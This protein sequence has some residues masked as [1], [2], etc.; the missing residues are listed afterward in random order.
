MKLLGLTLVFLLAVANCKG[1]IICEETNPP[2]KC[3]QTARLNSGNFADDFIFGVASS[4]YQI[5]GGRGRGLNVWDGFTHRFPEKGGADLG[6]GD[7]TCDAYRTWQ[8]DVDVMAELGVK[9]YRFSFAWSRI[10]PRGK[11]SR[12]VNEDG[13][14]YYS[15]LIDALLEKGITP[16]VTIY[17]WDLPQCLQ[18]EYEGFLS[19]EIIEDFKEYADLCFERFGDRVKNWITINQLFTVPT[20]GY[21]LGTDAPGRCSKWVS[22][23]CPGGDSATE[24]YLV[25]H[26]QLLAHAAAVDVY[27]RNYKY[28]GGKIGPVM[29]TR[30]F[31]PY[32]DTQASK[33]AVWRSKE[34]FFGWYMEPLTKG[35]YPDIM[36]QYVGSRLPNFTEAEARLVKGSY[37]FL[38]LN[39]YVTQYAQKADQAPPERLTAMTDSRAKLTSTNISKIPPGPPFGAGG[40]YYYPRG[41]LEVMKYFKERYGDPLIYV[42]ENGVSSTGGD[43]P[44]NESMAD[45]PRID[46][47]CSHL[48]FLRK[49]IDEF[50]VR[51][52]GYFAWSLG[53]NYEFCNGF[54]VRFGLSYVDFKNVTGDRDLKQSGLWYQRFLKA[55]KNP[56]KQDLL[57]SSLYFEK[58]QKLADA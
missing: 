30:W 27:R 4:A 55:G 7:T 22:E 36:R 24:P 52:K 46:Y 35:R 33:D 44:F 14:K 18:D 39:Y 56:V 31:L 34:F 28:Q 15:D 29:I 16:F 50:K 13:I 3:N 6:N 38:G 53:D 26:H 42:T 25:A 21:A 1:E 5:E 45:Y 10:L 43:T 47:L 32:D 19:R 12:G 51:V 57:R 49:A 58:N 23:T 17:H 37:D 41:M 2:F 20:R 11:R 40:G 48:C 54:T 9:G 8:K